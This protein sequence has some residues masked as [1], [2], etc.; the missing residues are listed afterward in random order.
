MRNG[1]EFA[2]VDGNGCDGESVLELEKGRYQV[3][4]AVKGKPGFSMDIAGVFEYSEDGLLNMVLDS[5]SIRKRDDW[6][7]CTEL[8]IIEWSEVLTVL[9]ALGINVGYEIGDDMTPEELSEAL[10]VE[11]G[12][13]V[14]ILD[15]VEFLETLDEYSL[16]F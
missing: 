1:E 14:W 3:F 6:V 4:I 9:E 16:Y 11:V 13:D 2:V 15:F 7:N 12:Q 8:F 5:I 10:G